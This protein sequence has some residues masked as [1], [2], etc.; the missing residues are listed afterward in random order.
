[1]LAPQGQ[2]CSSDLKQEEEETVEPDHTTEEHP[3]QKW[4][5]GRLAAK[6]PKEPQCEAFSKESGVVKVARQ[7]YFK[8]HWA[9]FKEE[10]SHDLSSTFWDMA[11]STN[12]LG[13]EVQEEWSSWQELRATNK[14]TKA[15]QRD[16]HF[17]RLVMPT[18]SPKI[19]GLEGIHLPKGL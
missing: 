17:F 15:F 8:T 5:G 18:E 2:C 12:L 16:I 19:M 1:M 3:C 9:N 4:K 10:G 14:T 13:N 11:S 7:A 6:A